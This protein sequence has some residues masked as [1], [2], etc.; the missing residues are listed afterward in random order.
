MFRVVNTVVVKTCIILWL[1]KLICP[2][3]YLR[4]SSNTV[5]SPSIAAANTTP[6]PA[7]CKYSSCE[8]CIFREW[9]V[10]GK[11]SICR[12]GCDYGGGDWFGDC[13]VGGAGSGDNVIQGHI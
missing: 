2:S 5:P 12:R 8:S 11:H 6:R 13:G 4:T 3:E 10:P 1:N 9:K 7:A